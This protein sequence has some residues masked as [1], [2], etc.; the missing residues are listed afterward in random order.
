MTLLIS[1][2]FPPQKGHLDLLNFLPIQG[3]I[4]N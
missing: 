3:A 4:I 1:I 2:D